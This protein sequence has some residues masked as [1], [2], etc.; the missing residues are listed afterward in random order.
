MKK[1]CLLLALI[2]ALTFCACKTELKDESL[3]ANSEAEENEQVVESID[4]EIETNLDENKEKANNKNAPKYKLLGKKYQDVISKFEED[5]YTVRDALN[6]GIRP[7]SV[8]RSQVF[9]NLSEYDV[10]IPY[11]NVSV[12]QVNFSSEQ[13]EKDF[14]WVL[15]F[16]ENDIVTAYHVLLET[17]D[18][19]DINIGNHID[20]SVFC[21]IRDLKNSPKIDSLKGTKQNGENWNNSFDGRLIYSEENY[22][23]QFNVAK[24]DYEKKDYTSDP[25]KMYATEFYVESTAISNNNSSNNESDFTKS[26]QEI[27]IDTTTFLNSKKGYWVDKTTCSSNDGQASFFYFYIGES[28]YSAGHPGGP[29]RSGDLFKVKQSNENEYTITLHYPA[30]EYFGDFY[31]EEFSEDKI[32]FNGNEFYFVDYPKYTYTYMGLDFEDVKHN[33]NEYCL[34]TLNETPLPSDQQLKES[35]LTLKLVSSP[36]L[37]NT[38]GTTLSNHINNVLSVNKYAG[39]NYEPKNHTII[40]NKTGERVLTSNL[41]NLNDC[42][43]AIDYGNEASFLINANINNGAI[44]RLYASSPHFYGN[45][46]LNHEKLNEY[47]KIVLAPMLVMFE[48][49]N[50]NKLVETLWQNMTLISTEKDKVSDVQEIV[51]TTYQYSISSTTWGIKLNLYM[52]YETSDWR[53]YNGNIEDSTTITAD[54]TVSTY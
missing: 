46:T 16:V 11:S 54:I 38:L 21:E 8:R 19:F 4:N 15:M 9:D 10:S 5:G 24:Y 7:Q 47:V 17:D 34:G 13:N 39:A 36:P 6:D 43:I 41:T 45:L 53:K 22:S 40:Y 37:S 27:T 30:E 12:F 26:N 1:L 20:T 25:N 23:V 42:K 52:M 29:S 50:S 49:D 31:E 14:L 28:V 35:Q 51:T 44:S 48:G 18:F 3:A 33:V 32:V 2:T